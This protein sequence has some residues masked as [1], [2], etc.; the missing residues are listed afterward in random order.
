[1]GRNA[2]SLDEEFDQLARDERVEAELDALKTR[3]RRIKA[4]SG[5]KCQ[6]GS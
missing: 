6:E 3:R 1:M 5:N 4:E 2:R